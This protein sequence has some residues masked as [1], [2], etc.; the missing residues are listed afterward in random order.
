MTQKRFKQVSIEDMKK[1]IKQNPVLKKYLDKG[2]NEY[3]F[4]EEEALN[5]M[6]EVWLNA[7]K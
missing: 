1:G 3:G 4:T 7:Y 2:I 6:M 5:I